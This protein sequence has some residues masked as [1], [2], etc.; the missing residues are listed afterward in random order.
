MIG[1]DAA[2]E[3]EELG[4]EWVLGALEDWGVQRAGPRVW[5]CCRHGDE[6]SFK[7]WLIRCARL[8]QELCGEGSV[9]RKRRLYGGE[10]DDC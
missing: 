9:F 1:W 7:C 8:I 10:L 6:A 2:V 5:R 3:S 4:L